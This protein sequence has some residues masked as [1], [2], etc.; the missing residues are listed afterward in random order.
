MALTPAASFVGLPAT[1]RRC[2]AT[3]GSADERT[4]MWPGALRLT[5]GSEPSDNCSCPN[6]SPSLV[7]RWIPETR[8]RAAYS[9]PPLERTSAVAADATLLYLSTRKLE[10]EPGAGVLPIW[11][12]ALN[13]L[14][15][16]E[17][18]VSVGPVGL[19]VRVPAAAGLRLAAR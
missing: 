14:S 18:S 19:S 7:R 4:S 13:L 16:I 5:W 2:E 9:A 3:R 17:P 10:V 15:W 8:L 6:T 1:T 11:R 12:R